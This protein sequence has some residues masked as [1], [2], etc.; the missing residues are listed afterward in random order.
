M[1]HGT[2][3]IIASRMQY[4]FPFDVTTMMTAVFD[5]IKKAR[6]KEQLE[7]NLLCNTT[8]PRNLTH[9]FYEEGLGKAIF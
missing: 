8:F 1:G 3:F 5:M 4:I 7:I 6:R 2:V 9:K